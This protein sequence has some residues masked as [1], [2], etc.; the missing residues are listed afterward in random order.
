MKEIAARGEIETDALIHYVIDGIVDDT[1]NKLCL[2]GARTLKDFK[3]KLRVYEKIK[4]MDQDRDNKRT[5]RENSG[6]WKND[7][8]NDCNK[9]TAKG[10]SRKDVRCFNCGGRGHEVGSVSPA[11]N[12]GMLQMNVWRRKAVS[13]MRLG[14]QMTSIC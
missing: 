11:I 13:L 12:S 4:K 8:K 3:E 6:S 10:S 2:F 7:N 5:N 1:R 9:K 14:N